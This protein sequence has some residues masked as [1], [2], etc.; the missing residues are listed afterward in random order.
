MAA[1]AEL[2][3]DASRARTLVQCAYGVLDLFDGSD[4]ALSAWAESLSAD[5]A[6][7]QLV[8][9]WFAPATQGALVAH[10]AAAGVIG[11][12][13]QVDAFNLADF[14]QVCALLPH[15]RM[16]EVSRRPEP[17][18]QVV[19][20][21]P[22][23]VQ[24]PDEAR[25]LQQSL[26]DRVFDALASATDRVLLCSPFWSDRGA[27]NLWDGL[28]RARAARLPVTLA[29]AKD[30]PGRDDL[31]AML[32]LADR[33]RGEG[34]MVRALRY[35]PAAAGSLFHAKV[36]GGDYGYLGSANLTGP[37]LGEHVEAGLP[38][39]PADV[40]RVWWLLGVLER[41]ELLRE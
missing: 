16:E 14:Q 33:L 4:A 34:M 21:V 12:G 11:N 20:T 27:D 28:G 32:R 9:A 37:G 25:H 18:A 26:S 36:V 10:L 6:G 5:R 30:D 7:D 40:E 17:G 24:L 8:P 41:A 1:T 15:F 19:F 22:P 39:A 13:G 2:T 35:V 29:G 38:L 31:G 23:A 3:Q